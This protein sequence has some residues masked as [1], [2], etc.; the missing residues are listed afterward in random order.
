MGHCLLIVFL[1]AAEVTVDGPDR[2]GA[3]LCTTESICMRRSE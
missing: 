1:I 3:I 2:V